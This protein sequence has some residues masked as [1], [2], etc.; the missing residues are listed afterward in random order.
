MIEVVSGTG[1]HPDDA[2]MIMEQPAGSAQRKS[3][4]RQR[5]T[6]PGGMEGTT[7]PL[8]TA[9][10]TPC[11]PPPPLELERAVERLP[12]GELRPEVDF[13]TR[14]RAYSLRRGLLP[15]GELELEREAQPRG[16][17]Q[18][19]ATE[20]RLREEPQPQGE[21]RLQGELLPQ[22]MGYNCSSLSSWS[23]HLCSSPQP[24]R[25]VVAPLVL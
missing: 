10:A 15:E 17:R 25:S 4:A 19:R 6:H 12:E 9:S 5:A 1:G 2:L 11:P 20:H 8:Y 3:S 7:A 18:P 13:A 24:H 16:E 21:K 23:A 14:G 22:G